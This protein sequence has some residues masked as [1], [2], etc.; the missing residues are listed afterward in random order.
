MTEIIAENI[1]RAITIEMRP[2]GIPRGVMP[3]LYEDIRRRSAAPLTLLAAEHLRLVSP[4]ERVFLATGAGAPVVLPQGETD[5][6]LGVAALARI[7]RLGLDA[8]PVVLTTTGFE[9]PI[10]AAL[11]A[12]ETTATIL[13]LDPTA[14]PDQARITAEEWL[15]GYAPSLA[16]AVEMKGGAS[17][18]QLHF[19]TGRVCTA[20]ARLDQVFVAARERQIRT[21]GVGDGGNEIGFGGYRAE[22]A[23]RHPHGDLIACEVP[24]DVL[25]V[26]AMSSW[27]CYGIETALA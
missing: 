11:D 6:P 2:R 3:G 5:G 16:I 24:T 15:D 19:M 9:D 1:D 20:D 10:R 4:G 13:S 22:V 21:I 14:T 8:E 18:G 17:D 26:A 27:G 12:Y 25:V 23:A 7:I